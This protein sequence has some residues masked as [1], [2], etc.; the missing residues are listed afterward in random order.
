MQGRPKK[1]K[2]GRLDFNAVCIGCGE[3]INKCTEIVPICHGCQGGHDVH[4]H[5]PAVSM[6]G[7]NRN[8]SI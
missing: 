6:L 1:D 7:K 5:L 8:Q 4:T 3:R 2:R